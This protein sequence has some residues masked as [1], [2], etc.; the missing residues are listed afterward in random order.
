[1]RTGEP[2]ARAT[3]VLAVAALLALATFGLRH[4]CSDAHAGDR[5]SDRCL[6]CATVASA[7]AA[8][9]APQGA[10]TPLA[11]RGLLRIHSDEDAEIVFVTSPSSRGPPS[12]A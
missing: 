11:V 9:S 8:L 6:T 3:A 1:M 12:L 7:T 10:S 5:L 2:R 4:V